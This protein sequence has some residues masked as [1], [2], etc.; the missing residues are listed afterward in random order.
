[1]DI[2]GLKEEVMPKSMRIRTIWNRYRV[3]A[4][5]AASV[6]IFAAFLTMLS[7]GYFSKPSRDPN[8][9][10][11]NR[12]VNNLERSQKQINQQISI[13]NTVPYNP[14]EFAATGFALTTNGYIITN[15]HVVQAAD[16]VHVQNT[17][18]ESFKAEVIYTDPVYDIA[19]LQVT[20]INFKSL[21]SLPYT[22]K[23]PSSD[24]GERVYTLGFPRDSPVYN[25]GY[26]SARTGYKGDTTTY[27]VAIPVNPGNSG[28]PLL[29]NKGNVIGI[30]S[31]KQNQADGV[32]F[33]VRSEYLLKSIKSLEDSLEV[34]IAINKKNSLS[35]LNHTAQIKKMQN[36]IFM[37]RAF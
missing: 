34:K 25:E 11:L 37:V 32:S 24:L 1:L 9:N 30:I 36:Y 21:K 28:G 15:Y 13:N 20:D 2:N 8:Y 7:T 31:A 26:L 27:Q 29:D 17:D 3:N 18:G 5:V 35:S 23:K 22:I 14:G 6:A 19:I 10:Y 16:S 33:A 12:K 4:A